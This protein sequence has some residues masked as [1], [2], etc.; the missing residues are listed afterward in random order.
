MLTIP[1]GR[2]LQASPEGLKAFVHPK[3]VMTGLNRPKG[4][5]GVIKR[6]AFGYL[7][8]RVARHMEGLIGMSSIPMGV[9]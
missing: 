3:A 9:I 1:T 5:D 6:G 7:L 4:G 8:V 2:K